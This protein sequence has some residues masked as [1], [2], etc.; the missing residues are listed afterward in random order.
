M[1]DKKLVI[2]ISP[3]LIE[4]LKQKDESAL[5]E[6]IN[7]QKSLFHY[8]AFQ[9]VK[10]SADADEVVIE[11]FLRIW[12]KIGTFDPE[13]GSFE[14][15]TICIV[16]FA[17]IDQFRKNLRHWNKLVKV[18]L[19][20]NHGT[21]EV[22]EKDGLEDVHTRLVKLLGHSRINEDEREMLTLYW[23]EGLSQG[24]ITKKVGKPLGTV[25]AR[26]RRGFKKLQELFLGRSTK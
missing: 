4:R 12:E 13:K 8:W 6:L 26:L 1:K 21:N 2:D 18:S 3:E 14:A 23:F 11:S 24:Q 16:R 19:D 15:W 9:C 5:T 22:V 25:K 7:G 17:A 20:I 10:N